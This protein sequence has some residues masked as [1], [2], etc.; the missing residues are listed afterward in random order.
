MQADAAE[1]GQLQAEDERLRELLGRWLR[2]ESR[3]L[4][5]EELA[6]LATRPGGRWAGRQAGTPRR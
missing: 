5:P 3:G 1:R 4:A 6:E 2:L